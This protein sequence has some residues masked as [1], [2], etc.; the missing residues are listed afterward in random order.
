MKSGVLQ[1]VT[2]L[3]RLHVSGASRVGRRTAVGVGRRRTIVRGVTD[4]SHVEV[5]AN[6][7]TSGAPAECE[8]HASRIVM[9]G[10]IGV[11][12]SHERICGDVAICTDWHWS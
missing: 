7:C 8:V 2:T 9:R 11:R 3:R 10:V 1:E 12:G 4:A 5:L 6:G